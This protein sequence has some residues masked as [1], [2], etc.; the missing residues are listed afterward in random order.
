ME[1]LPTS[2]NMCRLSATHSQISIYPCL[3]GHLF[4]RAPFD[5]FLLLFFPDMSLGESSQ[6][7]PEAIEI[8]NAK[9]DQ[10]S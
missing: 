8:N 10:T 6:L 4:K 9:P 1:K 7:Q 5:H 2:P 3:G